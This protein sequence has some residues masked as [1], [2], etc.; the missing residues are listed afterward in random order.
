M[1]SMSNRALA[2]SALARVL[3]CGS[4]EN[5][6]APRPVEQRSSEPAADPPSGEFSSTADLGRVQREGLW[7][8]LGPRPPRAGHALAGV[9][10]RRGLRE[11]RRRNSRLLVLI[12]GSRAVPRQL[13]AVLLR[14]HTPGD[15]HQQRR[16]QPQRSLRHGDHHRS[17]CNP[18]AFSCINAAASNPVTALGDVLQLV[19]CQRAA[20]SEE[21]GIPFES[22]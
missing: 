2:P 21:C 6:S 19:N 16:G 5:F 9:R 8:G 3:G 7:P 11:R 13:A 17:G 22:E 12:L 4:P 18:A 14:E 20:C 10:G 15:L 1:R